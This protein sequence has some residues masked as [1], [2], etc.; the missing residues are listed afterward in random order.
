MPTTSQAII[1][2]M[3]NHPPERVHHARGGG[4]LVFVPGVVLIHFVKN[5]D[6]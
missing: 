2:V 4:V 5:F 6:S 3:C 1:G